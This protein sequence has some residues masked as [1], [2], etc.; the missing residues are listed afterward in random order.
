MYACIC[1]YAYLYGLS[2]TDINFNTMMVKAVPLEENNIQVHAMQIAESIRYSLKIY[3]TTITVQTKC[4]LARECDVAFGL[5]CMVPLPPI[6][7][8]A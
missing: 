5:Y 1:T 2:T 8:V 3:R 6:F 7:T 4:T